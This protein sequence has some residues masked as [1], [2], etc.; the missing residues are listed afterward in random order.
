MNVKPELVNR[1]I[2]GLDL[3]GVVMD[4]MIPFCKTINDIYGTNFTKKNVTHWGFFTDQLASKGYTNDI[5]HDLF[6]QVWGEEIYELPPTEPNIGKVVSNIKDAGFRITV[7]T[8]R[9]KKGGIPVLQWLDKHRVPFDDVIM[10]YDM[11]PKND[12]PINYLVDDAIH[13]I[14]NLSYPKRGILFNQPWNS[15]MKFP[16]TIN[17][18]SELVNILSVTRL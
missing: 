14:E 5:E 6:E 10:I 8:K 17:N 16:I 9:T 1:P 12:F 3:D 15:Q 13:N 18:L 4:T 7:I 2:I 11:R